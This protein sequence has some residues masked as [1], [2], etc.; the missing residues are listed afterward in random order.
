MK[1]SWIIV[2]TL[3]LFVVPLSA[4]NKKRLKLNE[5]ERDWLNKVD[6]IITSD[7][8]KTFRKRLR[9]HHDRKR[10]IALFWSKRDPDLNDDTNPFKEGYLARYDFV[11]AHFERAK[12]KRPITPRSHILLLLGKPAKIEYRIDWGLMGFR[13]V[14]RL[15]NHRPE[16]WIYHELPYDYRPKRL[17]V[18]F[19]PFNQ[20]GDYYSVTDPYTAHWIRSLKHKFIVNP[21]LEM[22]PVETL[23]EEN[24]TLADPDTLPELPDEQL[25]PPRQVS[26]PT[27]TPTQT[28]VTTKPAASPEPVTTPEPAATPAAATPRIGAVE[29]AGTG[30]V[31]VP[32]TPG[33]T[34]R[35]AAEKA[36]EGSTLAVPTTPSLPK[37]DAPAEFN[38]A[39]SNDVGFLAN[40]GWFKRGKDQGLF[41]GRLGFPLKNL[42]FQYH[43]EQYEAPFLLRYAVI[44]A[45][46]EQ[47]LNQQV[48][49]RILVPKK[50]QIER[51]GSYFTEDFALVLKPDR[52]VLQME[53]VDQNNAA[54]SYHQ[55]PFE[56]KSVAEDRVQVVDFVLMDPN[57]GQGEATFQI[58]NQP[59]ALHLSPNIR[60]GSAFYPVLELSGNPS[61]EILDSIVF[62]VFRGDS[63]VREWQL[64]PEEMSATQQGTVLVH[65]VLESRQLDVGA[66]TLR[67][68]M[69]LADG[70]LLARE[71]M[72]EIR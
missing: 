5:E 47:V 12:S 60:Q 35:K 17:R 31:V 67:F 1:C 24:Y 6:L 70:E 34:R 57:I 40:H 37:G 2:A 10:F 28:A 25:V 42:D 26:G 22:A 41:M 30:K 16:L 68:E 11:M 62:S 45:A 72:I 20:W 49:R 32:T 48:S 58:R 23:D 65:P 50:E 13:N 38:R 19:I 59:F 64:F 44:N 46:G 56:L 33:F 15:L 8:L 61:S 18:Q 7:E 3:L 55:I 21:E 71:M 53:L 14:N 63:L 29:P 36:P 27:V 66:Y 9:T 54:T 39:A 43:R 69:A 4:A 52:Y 51:A